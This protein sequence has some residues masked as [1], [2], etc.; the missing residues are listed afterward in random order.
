MTPEECGT[1]AFELRKVTANATTLWH[2]VG[3]CRVGTGSDVVVDPGL[4]VYDIE[5]FALSTRQSCR[6]IVAESTKKSKKP[7][8]M[9]GEKAADLIKRSCHNQVKGGQK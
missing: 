2:P 6:Q 3:T 8:V 9:I 7:C 1:S 5:G 4:R